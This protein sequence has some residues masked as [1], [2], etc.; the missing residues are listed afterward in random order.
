MMSEVIR[1]ETII[2]LLA[3]VHGTG[4]TFLYDLFRALRR[5]VP[6]GAAAISAED[7]VFWI[8]AGF[9]TFC[10]AF[11]YTDGVIRA[12]VSA[13]I[14]IGAV[15]YHFTVSDLVIKMA[16]GIFTLLKKLFSAVFLFWKVIFRS[17]FLHVIK[18]CR[19]IGRFLKK[20]I[21]FGKK[22]RYNGRKNERTRGERC[23]KKKET[24]K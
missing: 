5:A 21:E 17:L 3:V 9:L 23:G 22:R 6:H 13:G 11:S 15:L 24:S 1:Q 10:F 12:Y 2:F 20:T 8:A 18:L 19:K 7:F 16:A 4:L 14:A